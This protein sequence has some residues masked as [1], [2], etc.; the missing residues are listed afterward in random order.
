MFR[1]MLDASTAVLKTCCFTATV[2]MISEDDIS[3]IFLRLEFIPYHFTL[4]LDFANFVRNWVNVS[5]TF[6]P[7]FCAN[8]KGISS[9]AS[10]NLSTAIC[11]LPSTVSDRF[12][13]FCAIIPSAEPA[14]CTM[15]GFSMKFLNT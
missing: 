10:A 15:K 9:T 7:I 1:I 8:V 2:S 12:L 6:I 13:I 3:D 5:N 4:P 11:S 14:P